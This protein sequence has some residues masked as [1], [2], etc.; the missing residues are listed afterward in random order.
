MQP[1]YTRHEDDTACN[2]PEGRQELGGRPGR[3]HRLGRAEIDENIG[4][5]TSKG[6]AKEKVAPLLVDHGGNHGG[7]VVGAHHDAQKQDDKC[8]DRVQ[9]ELVRGR[10]ASQ[11][12][13]LVGKRVCRRS[14]AHGCVQKIA[15]ARRFNENPALDDT[16]C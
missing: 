4:Q 5:C 7:L 2:E 9:G 16:Q 1:T 15:D 11:L 12:A 6:S 3:Q 10:G 8:R 14:V 13:L